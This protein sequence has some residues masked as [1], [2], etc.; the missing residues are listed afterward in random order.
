[1]KPAQFEYVAP[2]T[3]AAAIEALVASNGEGKVLAGG[4]SLLPLLN[5]RMARPAVL[6]DLNG[7]EGLSYIEDRGD[8]IAIG[9]LTRHRELEHSPLIA[10]KLPVMSAAM[11]HVAHLAIRNRGTIGGSL[12]HADPAAEL[13]MLATFY[14]ARIAVQGPSGRRTIAPRDFFVDALTNCL[15]PEE[16]VVE[17]EFPVLKQDGWA[18]EEVARRFGDFALAS[19]AVSVCRGPT[20]VAAARVAVMGVADT[21][22]RLREAE[23]ELVAIGLDDTT[24]DRFAEIVVSLVAPNDDL[25]ASADYRK[26]L[27]AQLAKR[28]LLA[29]LA[30]K[31]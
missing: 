26:H 23:D 15:E 9:A 19:I 27:L 1:M 28:A 4:Q 18:F 21:P 5:F 29:A 25:H 14:E 2:S 12:S 17:V 10:S 24:P 20:G 3:V 13:P 16:I 11:R 8:R 31:G 30:M 6:V 7:I 22:R